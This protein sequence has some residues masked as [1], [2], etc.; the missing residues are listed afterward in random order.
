MNIKMKT[1]SLAVL[2]LA[3]FGIAGS[4]M[5]QTCSNTNLS[6]WSGMSSSGGTLAVVAPGLN[7]PASACKMNSSLNSGANAF[8]SA[9]V[10]DDTPA[11]ELRYRAQFLVNADA[12]LSQQAFASA[13]VFSLTSATLNQSTTQVLRL[14]VSGGASKVLNIVVAN[15]GAAGNVSSDSVTLAAGVNR[16]EIDYTASAT[17]SVKVWVNNTTEATPTRNLTALNNVGWGGIERATMGVSNANNLFATSHA[18][19]PVAFDQF[20]S[21]RQTFI[22]AQ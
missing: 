16:V 20:D 2:G 9:T 14:S 1:L 21:R 3:S 22:G 11:N 19:Q 5:A 15:Q 13:K 17:G 4:V 8:S 6:A 12:V 7:T 10:R 18:A